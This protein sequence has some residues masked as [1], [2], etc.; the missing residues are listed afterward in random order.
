M[1][2]EQLQAK[3]QHFREQAKQASIASERFLGAA[4]A[5]EEML[6][7]QLRAQ[8]QTNGEDLSRTRPE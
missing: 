6:Q 2:V 7:E 4:L 3:I 5:C 1:T 8:Q